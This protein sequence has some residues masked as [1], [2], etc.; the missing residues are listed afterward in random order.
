[1]NADLRCGCDVF[2]LGGRVFCS[3]ENCAT[4]KFFNSVGND[5]ADAKSFD[6]FLVDFQTIGQGQG[7]MD[8]T[9]G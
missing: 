7:K 3:I 4:R 9:R 2:R 5:R 1:M 8:D 6:K